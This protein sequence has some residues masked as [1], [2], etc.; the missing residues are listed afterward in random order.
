M[1]NFLRKF[2]KYFLWS[3]LV[4]FSLIVLAMILL[5]VPGV[6]N[7]VKGKAVQY[8]ERNLDMDMSVGR[9]LLKFPLDLSIEDIYLGH[10]GQDT[11]VAA[12]AIRVNVALS[13]LI[14][15]EIEV[16]RLSVENAAFNIEDTLSGMKMKVAVQELAL[17]V[18]RLNLGQQEAELPS[19]SLRGGNVVMRLGENKPD[20]STTTEAL[21]WKITVG[22]VLLDSINY[23][24]NGLPMGEISAGIGSARLQSTRVDLGNQT[25]NLEQVQLSRGYC[26]LLTTRQDSLK[27][28]AVEHDTV[29]TQPWTVRVGR[30]ELT[31]NHF[32]MKPQGTTRETFPEVIRLSALSLQMDSVFN[33]GMEIAAIIQ[34][35]Q[36]REG[37]G[38]DL[39]NLSCRVDI[40]NTQADVSNLSLKTAFSQ[41]KMNVQANSGLSA[42]GMDT[43]LRL[44]INGNIGGKDLL[45][46]MP[47]TNTVLERFLSDNTFTVNSTVDGS[48]NKLHVA[49]LDVNVGDDF[50]LKSSGNVSSVTD[51]E[52]MAANLNA[53]ITVG[54]GDFFRVFLPGDGIVIP[55]RLTL[56]TDIQFEEQITR[57]RVDM[58]QGEGLLD[59]AA[60]YDLKDEAYRIDLNLRDFALGEFMPR[61]SLGAVT[62]TL[63]AAGKGFE[64]KTAT[65]KINLA[66]A[67][68]L[69]KAYDY[70]DIALDAS[71][72]DGKLEG[73]IT[74][75]SEALDL[76]L[77]FNLITDNGGY[78]AKV[79]S[80]IRNID[81]KSLHFMPKDMAF[82]LGLAMEAQ[83][84]ADSTSS[85][86]ADFSNIVL[87][88]IATRQLG[89][90]SISFSGEHRRTLLNIVA[91]DLNIA[92]TGLTGG[93]SLIDHFSRAGTLLSRQLTDHDFNMEELENA[94][95]DF[96]LTVTAAQGNILNS[97]LKSNGIRFRRLTLDLGTNVAD[98]FSMDAAVSGLNV[99]G[100][101]VDSLFVKGFRQGIALHYGI[102]VFGAKEQFEGL[103]QLTVE[104]NLEH[105]QL[106]IRL[107]EHENK[108]GEIF[109]IGANIAFQDSILNV[110]ISPEPLVLGY[111][112]WQ[113]NR[114]NFIRVK[115]GEIP[116]AN[117]Q[118]LNGDKR[119]RLVSEQGADQRPES[120]VV[121]IKGIDLG[122]ISKVLTFIPDMSGLLGID[123]QM[124]NRDDVMDVAGDIAIQEFSY[125]QQR[126][127]NLGL[128]IKYR[129]SRQTE[130][131]IDLSL[132]VDG[133]KALLTQGT[134][135]TGKDD[136]HID[137]GIDIP[138]FPLRV[139]GAFVPPG[140]IR[141]GGALTGNLQIKGQITQP[142][143]NGRLSFRD[144]EV[145]VYPV[146]TTF[147]ID[148]SR[149]T[150][151][152]NVL[153][154][155]HFG[156]ISPNRQRLE[157]LGDVNFA[158]FSAIEM[159]ASVSARNFQAMKVEENSETM[160]YGKLFIDLSATL[161]GLL[162]DL[163][164]RGNINLLDNS[165]VYYTLKSS[166][167]S[168][169]DRSL[170]VVR[171]VSFR[172]S[173]RVSEDDEV[174]QMH[175]MS[176]DLLMSVNIAP[177]VNLNVLL[178]ESGQNRVSINGGGSLTYT[179][180]SVGESRLVG[181]YVL[182]SGIVSYGLPVIG[183]K[184]FIIQD[185][186][187]VEWTGNL[188]N[189]TLNIMAAESISASV[190]DDS[191]KSR[192]VT[193]KAMIRITNTL[194]KPDITFDLAAEGDITIQNQLA[195]MTPEERSREAMN[196]MIYGTYSGPGT[197]AK[198]NAS[199]NALNNFVEKELNQWSR[200][201][202]K[203][204]DLTFGI[205]TYNQVSEGGESKK[206]D[207][208]YQFSKRLF[209]NRV[210]VKVGGRISTDNDPAAGGVEENLVDDISVE[211][212][213]GKN[214]NFFLKIF[215]HTG[216]ESVLEGEVTQTGI[217]LVLRK[218]F[219]KF[220]DIFRRKKKVWMEQKTQPLEN[221]KS[222][223]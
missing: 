118:L 68:F 84:N 86:Q 102:D 208:S 190:T 82:S 23:V 155:N 114:G 12:D 165:E 168:V 131:D 177:L 194:D 130:H 41:L 221:E 9:I 80:D 170:D 179:L 206:T 139:A 7:F 119:I 52:K 27:T 222:G 49:R 87:H 71:L 67:S 32:L 111:V 202:L 19:I 216:Y 147:Q 79:A 36:L 146:G 117:L 8:V 175:T 189:P 53:E 143:I 89:D 62:A 22:E 180:S 35:I 43:P 186:N 220:K 192:L 214:P 152:D 184:D 127:G 24:M 197:V 73:S 124:H 18:D 100:F 128:D 188:A 200:K 123:L 204:M 136:Q 90:L 219:Q 63:E 4:L 142:D 75:G 183:Q 103:A 26:D 37:N 172:D 14:H 198:S 213:F 70:T 69:Y 25:V 57:A 210:R 81:L 66:L 61:D 50:L 16:R 96:R 13:K 64:V 201:H 15:K 28:V 178:S 173:T 195:A 74:S 34:N 56:H 154:F 121:D 182:T 65:A 151:Q 88:D 137:L 104:G 134:L 205:N 21:R 120:L 40:N 161:K 211:Y 107:R 51:M 138:Q 112:P 191:Q 48:I 218:N 54:R 115:Q 160:V 47:D 174:R 106:N 20:T 97:Y 39:R 144:G 10:A 153:H 3:I 105:D 215:R 223:Q 45:L 17:K 108:D 76:D 78:K 199:D 98:R 83:L 162:D 116:A 29:E 141:L 110:S 187:Y 203:N 95:P 145:E 6:Q 129:L 148:S 166:P 163:K 132:S 196:M 38:L 149:I 140:I 77:K 94:L 59:L 55:D 217:G 109:N 126:V 99:N 58:T 72:K 209:N 158:S 92:F 176:L 125:Q 11:L 30:V 135:F 157:L 169:T 122:H 91:G 133:E 113:I 85:M 44:S 171:F 167:L 156:L 33:Q 93:Y 164:I 46:F 212:L 60:N 150:V 42:F 181:R 31:D 2:L 1:K 185:G 5:Y 207:Y 159:D 101:V 193:F